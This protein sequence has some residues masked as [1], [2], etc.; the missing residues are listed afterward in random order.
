[1]IVDD[2]SFTTAS[3]FD[4]VDEAVVLKPST[5]RRSAV[6]TVATLSD[7]VAVP[8]VPTDSD[9]SLVIQLD[10]GENRA[11]SQAEHSIRSPWELRTEESLRRSG[12][13]PVGRPSHNGITVCNVQR[14]K[15]YKTSYVVAEVNINNPC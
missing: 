4:A 2:F 8:E 11:F 5:G 14:T 3:D 9:A 12:H 6:A 15:C 10:T 13:G 1:M 7:T